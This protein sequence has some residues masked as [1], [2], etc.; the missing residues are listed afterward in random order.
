MFHMLFLMCRRKAALATRA[1]LAL[2]LIALLQFTL[3]CERSRRPTPLAEGG[4]LDLSSWNF[5][6]DG[7]AALKGQWEFLWGSSGPAGHRGPLIPGG[8]ADQYP[9]PALWR[10]PTALGRPVSPYGL[11]TYRLRVR[12]GPADGHHALYLAGVLS[13]CQVWVDGRFAGSNGDIDAAAGSESPRE[14]LILPDFVPTGP[15]VEI[16]LVVS[17]HANAQGGLNTPVFFGTHEQIGRMVSLRWVTGA[18][19][20]GVLLAMGAYH[21]VVFA[22]RRT[23]RA[24][25]Y[26]GLFALAWSVATLF[27]PAS[28][29]VVSAFT[30]LPWR[31][32]IDLALLPY[33]L[34]IPLMVALYH[35]LFPKRFG[36]GVTA[37]YVLL[38]GVYIA[39]LLL[40][41]PSAFGRVPLIYYMVTRTAFLYLFVAFATD[42]LRR[43]RGVLILAPGY[44]AL[45]Y[46]ELSKILFDL[47]VTPSADFAP[48]GM[49]AFILAHSLFMSVRFSQAFLKVER[50][51]GELEANN[52]RLV[53]LNRLK[54]EFLANATHELKTPLAGMVGIAES[55]L[56]GAG[57]PMTETAKGHLHMLSHSG[58]RLSRLVDDVLEHARLENMDVKLAPEAVSLEKA[59]RRTLALT[60]GLAADKGL[61]LR[62][63]LP[64]SLP[65]VLADPGRLEQILFNLVGN[66]IKYTDHGWVELSARVCGERMEIS[67]ADTGVGIAP[68]DLGG[69]FESYSQLA[70]SASGGT[71]G[72][73]LGLAIAKRLVELHGG[74]LHVD[75]EPGRGSVFSFTLPLCGAAGEAAR[76]SALAPCAAPPI[77]VE[78]LGGGEVPQGAEGPDY[79]VLAVD[80]EPV[81]LH[82]V[83][84]CLAVAGISF[85]TARSGA[86]ALDLLAA[87][88]NPGM[89]LLDVMMPGQD[90]YAVCRKIRRTRGAAS[91]PV[92]MLT[93]RGRVEDVLEGFAAGA[94]DYVTK[95]FAREELVA[96]VGT[97][98]RLAEAHRVLEEN[99]TL[100]REVAMR[101]KTEQELRLRQLRLSRMLDAIGEAVFAVNQS[102][103]IA[104]CNQ[105]FETRTGRNAQEILGQ[106]LACLLATPHTPAALALRQ[107]LDSML[108]GAASTISFEAVDIATA[109]ETVLSCRLHAVSL[110]LEDEALL[111]ISLGP[112]GGEGDGR[113]AADSATMLR[114]VEGNRQRLQRI[115]EALL[116]MEGGQ[117][118]AAVLEDLNAIDALLESICGKLNGHAGEPDA[119]ELAVQVMQAALDCWAEATGKGKGELAIQS[120]LW[121]AY[122][123]R[124][125]Y[126][127]TQTL[128]KYLAV[129][130]LPQRPRW[131]SVVATAEFVL[132]ACPAS[133]RR[134]DELRRSLNRMQQLNQ[135]GRDHRLFPPPP[136]SP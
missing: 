18:F 29:F 3:G 67:V 56:A 77:L 46:A 116:A 14:H 28:G 47:H 121:N 68:G 117:A 65:P 53:R 103:E 73:G 31:L 71:G 39:S 124:D 87:G 34:T 98:L 114:R 45:A 107:E 105:A 64:E 127:R 86:D 12:M 106:P 129:E 90:G 119:R 102:R 96:R 9:V 35:A 99:A 48:Y 62:D 25:L 10:A 13:V 76:P 89:V 84:T 81:N 120:G 15:E 78:G 20:S 85:K 97:Q 88:D 101:S 123:E 44:L 52:E 30:R 113:G 60:R 2:A 125:G 92:V 26:F 22:M 4:V 17:N 32:H 111:L 82:V 5:E 61:A 55:L 49:L 37:F 33:G 43:E 19:L 126:L 58:K 110:E 63:S 41:G 38:G 100:R 42:I 74:E 7:P 118:Q 1:A 72:A 130:T 69:I 128:D 135:E 6:M 132:S 24:N 94:N 109:G 50:L 131:L 40:S 115:S 133:C 112:T 134:C 93:C 51:S 23:D 8:P 57:G 11:A 122:M 104:F 54:D 27:S 79:Q 16:V 95:P 80:D 91:L 70:A 21:L 108:E 59:A 136:A 83:A 75:S 36:R 66:G